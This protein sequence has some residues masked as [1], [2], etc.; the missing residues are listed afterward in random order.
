MHVWLALSFEININSGDTRRTCLPKQKA[1]PIARLPASKMVC[2]SY[3]IC[4]LRFRHVF[5]RYRSEFVFC[6]TLHVVYDLA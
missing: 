4:F 6:R 5:I 2:R 3:Y 1:R